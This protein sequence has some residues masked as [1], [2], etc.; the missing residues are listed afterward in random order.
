[1]SKEPMRAPKVYEAMES[2]EEAVLDTRP[3]FFDT[4][5]YWAFIS[6]MRLVR[7]IVIDAPAIILEHERE[8][9]TRRVAALPIYAPGGPDA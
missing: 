4:A 9:L 6:A 1:M 2:L 7:L 8:I 5:E 3:E